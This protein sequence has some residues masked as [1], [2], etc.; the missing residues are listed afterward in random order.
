MISLHSQDD[1]CSTKN[2]LKAKS[3]RYH[4]RRVRIA[5]WGELGMKFF[6]NGR[7]G[8]DEVGNFR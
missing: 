6:M 7:A 5:S 2:S 3:S 4:C 1:K 8:I